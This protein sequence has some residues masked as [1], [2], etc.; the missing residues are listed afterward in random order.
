[1]ICTMVGMPQGKY[2]SKAAKRH[3]VIDKTSPEYEEEIIRHL[4]GDEK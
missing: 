4:V 2:S 3:E 1:M